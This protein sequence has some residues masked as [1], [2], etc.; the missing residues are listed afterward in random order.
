[1]LK[2]KRRRVAEPLR[3]T[4]RNNLTGYNSSANKFRGTATAFAPQYLN[5]AGTAMKQMPRNS[6]SSRTAKSIAVY[7]G[8]CSRPESASHLTLREREWIIRATRAAIAD[9]TRTDIMVAAGAMTTAR[10]T[11]TT[12]AAEAM[13]DNSSANGRQWTTPDVTTLWRQTSTSKRDTRA[14]GHT[15]LSVNSFHEKAG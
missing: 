13:A 5:M 9:I 1:M 11:T 10:S 2:Q 7:D 3:L 8:H 4:N 12:A 6:V 14:H 15:E